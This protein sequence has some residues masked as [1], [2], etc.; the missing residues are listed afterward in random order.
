MSDERRDDSGLRSALLPGLLTELGRVRARREA[1]RRA[2]AGVCAGLLALGAILGTQL[3]LVRGPRGPIALTEPPAKTVVL[4]VTSDPGALARA[5]ALGVPQTT[6]EVLDD[7][8][9]L[10][11]LATAGRPA[12]LIR[13]GGRTRLSRDVTDPWPEG[14]G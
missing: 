10:D 7:R 6:V 1:R 4:V 2:V 14:R 9:L 8:A 5:S 12:G 13:S 11:L 3:P